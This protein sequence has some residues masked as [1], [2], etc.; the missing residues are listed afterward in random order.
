MFANI[1]ETKIVIAIAKTGIIVD[2]NPRASPPMMLGAAPV[3]QDSD[4]F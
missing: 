4:S 1:K 2:W 3:R